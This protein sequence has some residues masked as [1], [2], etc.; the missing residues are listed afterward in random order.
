MGL[1]SNKIFPFFLEKAMS[2]KQLQKQ[3]EHLLK[4]A[5][6]HVL[7]IGF[8]TGLNV[9]YYSS[10]VQSITAIDINPGMTSRAKKRM[11]ASSVPIQY[12][13]ASVE[14]LPFEDRSF[15]TIVSTWTLCSV[16]QIE[17]ALSEIRRTLKPDGRFLFVEHGLSKKPSLKR[18]QHF[19]SPLWLK[20]SLGCYLDRNIREILQLSG[21]KILEG[22][23][24]RLPGMLPIVGY[25]YRGEATLE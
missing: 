10:N 8:G 15:D 16:N 14:K 2:K 4:T 21:F 1:Y 24:F 23:E 6:G 5:K 9:P 13:I 19:L 20:I 3:R 18:W 12:H 22:K 17:K 25:T 7:E 11:R